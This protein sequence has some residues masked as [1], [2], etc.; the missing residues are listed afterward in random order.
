MKKHLKIFFE[1]YTEVREN[2]R[3]SSISHTDAVRLNTFLLLMLRLVHSTITAAETSK[4]PG[5]RFDSD[6]DLTESVPPPKQPFNWKKPFEDLAAYIGI[7]PSTGKLVRAIKTS[8]SVLISAVVAFTFRD[9][10]EAYGWVYWAPMTTALVSDSS[11]GGTLRL[12]FQ[13]LMAVLL[14]STYAYVIVLIT[15]DHVAVGVCITIFVGLMGY[16]KTDPRKEYFASV[17]GQSASII[18]FL[19]NQKGQK[20]MKASNQAVL[21]R[22]SLTFLGVFIHVL[23]SNSFLPVTARALTKKKVRRFLFYSKNKTFI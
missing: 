20:Q 14:G 16:L 18:T 10:L 1:I 21:A 17:C 19:S 2:P 15:Q 3:Y 8:L 12:S 9:R 7:R 5:A 11:E 22:T 6:E 13:R 4:T 23:I